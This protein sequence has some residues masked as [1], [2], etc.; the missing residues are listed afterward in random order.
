MVIYADVLFGIN[1]LADYALLRVVVRLWHLPSKRL[2]LLFGAAVGALGAI[3]S[4]W[5]PPAA[6]FLCTLP[7]CA[8]V[9][10]AA[11]CPCTL[12]TFLRAAAGYYLAAFLLS[13]VLLLVWQIWRPP[14]LYIQNNVVYYPIPVP[15]FFVLLC[16]FYGVFTLLSALTGP[17]VLEKQVVSLRIT[18]EGKSAELFAGLDTGCSLREPFSGLPVLVAEASALKQVLPA[19]VLACLNE[20]ADAL[21]AG[22]RLIPYAALGGEGLLPAFFPDRVQV[23][24]TGEVLRCWVAVSKKSLGASGFSAVIDP[25]ALE[26]MPNSKC[27]RF[28]GKAPREKKG[29]R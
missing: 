21:S 13:G 5:L 8:G 14:G 9:I 25:S 7:V 26:E 16:V 27:K 15:V 24:Q 4:V 28:W 12:R 17:P 29:E 11:F 19:S 6:S 2:R 20:E 3:V 1:L 22:L 18:C 23:V 10:A